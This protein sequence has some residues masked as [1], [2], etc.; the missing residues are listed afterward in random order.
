MAL[1]R[2]ILQFMILCVVVAY[3]LFYGQRLLSGDLSVIAVIYVFSSLG[4]GI[5]LFRLRRKELQE[6]AL[7][8][9]R[10][11]AYLANAKARPYSLRIEEKTLALQSLREKYSRSELE[12]QNFVEQEKS[13]EAEIAE[14][15]MLDE[16]VFEAKQTI[17]R[18]LGRKGKVEIGKLVK[19]IENKEVLDEAIAELMEEDLLRPS[20][21]GRYIFNHSGL[22]RSID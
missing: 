10:R 19:G 21:A 20:G 2:S 12:E 7:A 14:L 18:E 15:S 17:L 13:L 4:V 11:H 5:W 22:D 6:R 9:R 8:E 1:A 16:A 3:L